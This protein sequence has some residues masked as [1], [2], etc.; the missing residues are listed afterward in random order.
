MTF[1]SKHTFRE[2]DPFMDALERVNAIPG[3]V[4]AVDADITASDAT[5]AAKLTAET[6]IPVPSSTWTGSQKITIGTHDFYWDGTAWKPG[7]ASR[8]RAAPGNTFPADAQITLSDATNAAK[9]P[10]EG[11]R[12]LPQTNWTVGQK[13]TI[14]TFDF[15]WNGSAWAAGAHA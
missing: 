8:Y 15:N 13:I 14:G 1:L 10:G 11:F 12:A 4:Y 5:N 9:L 3:T 6:F 7:N 2:D